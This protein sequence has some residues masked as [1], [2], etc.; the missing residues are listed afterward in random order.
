V[1]IPRDTGRFILRLIEELEPRE[2]ELIKLIYFGE[3]TL[4]EA[5]LLLGLSKSW[6]SRLHG[7]ALE[8]LRRG[9]IRAVPPAQR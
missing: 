2:A 6:L 5:R 8:S 7:F 3:A 4:D 1:I 9:L